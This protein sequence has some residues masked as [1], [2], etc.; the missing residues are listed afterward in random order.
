MRRTRS[1]NRIVLCNAPRPYA[2]RSHF[3]ASLTLGYAKLVPL[4]LLICLHDV[5][6]QA[7]RPCVVGV[8]PSA[9]PPRW[10]LVM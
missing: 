3:V 10:F 9:T 6:L 8:T 2:W 4:V 7:T 1:L 5:A